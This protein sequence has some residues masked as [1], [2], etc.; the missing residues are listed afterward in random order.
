MVNWCTN[1]LLTSDSSPWLN[2]FSRFSALWRRRRRFNH[3]VTSLVRNTQEQPEQATS[4]TTHTTAPY[5]SATSSTTHTTEPYSSMYSHT[6]SLTQTLLRQQAF[7]HTVAHCRAEFS[8]E[9]G[10]HDAILTLTQLQ[11]LWARF[12]IWEQ[13]LMSPHATNNHKLIC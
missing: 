12:I 2:S 8:P 9:T 13:C 6:S 1:G 11:M 4:S 7:L 5:S 3:P 10:L